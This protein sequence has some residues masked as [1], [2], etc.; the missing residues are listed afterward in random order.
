MLVWW[1][2]NGFKVFW[3]FLITVIELYSTVWIFAAVSYLHLLDRV[4]SKA[5]RHNDGLVVCDLENRCR[6]L[7]LCMFCNIR[8]NPNHAPESALLRSEYMRCQ[9]V[10]LF[11][12]IPDILM[13]LGLAQSNFE[14]RL[15]LCFGMKLLHLGLG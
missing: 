3:S 6:F 12:F 10:W 1:S 5:V 14:E 15:F 2:S 4:V 11:L 9:P 13:F 7:A 8:V